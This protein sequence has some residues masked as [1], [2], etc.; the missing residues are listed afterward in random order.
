V[1]DGEKFIDSFDGFTLGYAKAK[2]GLLVDMLQ[3][4]WYNYGKSFE[5]VYHIYK[6]Y[7][8]STIE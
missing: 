6:M 4:V 5:I 1:N 3:F 7:H 2:S 8:T